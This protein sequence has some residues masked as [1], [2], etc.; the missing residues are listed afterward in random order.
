MHFSIQPVLENDLAI[1]HPLAENDFAVLY[2]VASDPQIWEQHPNR[3]R[4]KEDA[5]R[6]Y[7]EGAMQS[8]GAFKVID[9]A[10]G[11]VAGST[12]IYDYNTDDNSICIGYTFY[13]REY[14]GKGLNHAVKAMMLDYLFRF[15]SR[16]DFHIGAVNLRS[17]VS[18]TRLG[19]RKV[20]ELEVAYYG[21]EAKPNFIFC[22]EREEWKS[23]K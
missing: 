8:G 16:V 4:W 20:G 19:A 9:K 17:Q 1:L 22:I 23:K 5:F 11:N 7:F 21:E 3:D 15:V 2:A 14:W 6:N 13:G 12:R 10:T 18:I